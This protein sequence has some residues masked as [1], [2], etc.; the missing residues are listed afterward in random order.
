MENHAIK[1]LEIFVIQFQE[2]FALLQMELIFNMELIALPQTTRH[3]I[4]IMELI[5]MIPIS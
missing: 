2:Y 5:V 4:K 1:I 3:A